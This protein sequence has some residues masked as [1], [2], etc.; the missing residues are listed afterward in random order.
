MAS[1]PL[2]F[3]VQPGQFSVQSLDR[4]QNHP[5]GV[6]RQDPIRAAHAEGAAEGS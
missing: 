3:T 1:Q 2:D 5:T 4:G 6:H